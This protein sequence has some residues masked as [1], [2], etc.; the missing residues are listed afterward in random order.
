MASGAG[1]NVTISGSLSVFIYNKKRLVDRLSHIEKGTFSLRLFARNIR[2]WYRPQVLSEI[3]GK[4]LFEL[5]NLE[6]SGRVSVTIPYFILLLA[7]L[8]AAKGLIGTVLANLFE[9]VVTPY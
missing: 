6:R 8:L 5:L 1:L 7:G 3:H 2:I 9:S 4:S